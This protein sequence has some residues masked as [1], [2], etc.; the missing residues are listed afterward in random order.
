MKLLTLKIPETPLA[1][2]VLKMEG[3]PNQRNF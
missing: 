3:P 1:R 2:Y